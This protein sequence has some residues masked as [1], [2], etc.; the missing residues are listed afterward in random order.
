MNIEVGRAV[1]TCKEVY[2]RYKHLDY[3]FSDERW[4]CGNS[5]APFLRQI[6]FDLWQAI[7]T[8][9]TKD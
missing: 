8:E 2:E 9:A 6:T 3:L 5:D 7:K 1:K 4:L